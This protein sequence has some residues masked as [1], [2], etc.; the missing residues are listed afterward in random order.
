M[1]A[2]LQP[3]I[4]LFDKDAEAVDPHAVWRLDRGA[5]FIISY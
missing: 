3:S 5:P 1:E 4:W 2:N